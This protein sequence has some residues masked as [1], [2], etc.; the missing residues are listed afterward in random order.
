MT[1]AVAPSKIAW[2]T[3]RPSLEA[4]VQTVEAAKSLRTG[5]IRRIFVSFPVAPLGRFTISLRLRGIFALKGVRY[6]VLSVRHGRMLICASW[7]R[8]ITE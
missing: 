8:E 5:D 6:S 3:F 7:S 4:A 2:L 1:S